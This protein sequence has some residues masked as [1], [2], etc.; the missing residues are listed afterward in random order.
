[1]GPLVSVFL[2]FALH[3]EIRTI[4][5]L[6]FIPAVLAFL[7]V[8]LVSSQPAI[9][10]EVKKP[11]FSFKAL[12]KS[13]WK[14]LLITAVFGL[15][16]LS[17]AFVI[18][19]AKNIGLS[20]GVTI[21]IY[22]FF[23]LAAAITSFPIGILSDKLGRKNILLFCFLVFIVSFLGFAN[24][25]SFILMAGLFLLYGV[26]Q[27][28]F[29]AVGKATA[30]DLVPAHL[31]ASGV[32]WYSTTVGLSG[33]LASVI[34]GQLWIKISPSATFYYGAILGVLALI[35]LFFAFPSKLQKS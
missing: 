11:P 17:S 27:G 19:Q 6:T 29:R 12:P 35:F 25:K 20:T 32:G 16:N 18:L 2:I 23:N 8:F 5:Y 28:T 33:F 24:S 1:M 7:L 13:Y 3:L 21:L 34:G 9:K 14:Y 31:K 22:A 10:S 15:G 4:F 26:F 30:V